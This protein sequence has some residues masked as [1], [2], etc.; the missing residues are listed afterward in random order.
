MRNESFIDLN[1]IRENARTIKR[2]LPKGVKLCAV[3]KS[4]AY[5]H[6]AAEVAAALYNVADCFA[7]ALTEEGVQLRQSGIDKDVLV[8]IP[9]L[10]SDIERAV[11]YNLTLT[12]DNRQVIRNIDEE[13]LKR[14]VKTKIHLKY[15]TGMNRFGVDTPEELERLCKYA[16][17]KNN[18]IIDGMFSHYACPE[19]D[20]LRKKARDKFLLAINVVKR[21]NK[22][23]TCHISAS[24]GF[25][26]GDYFDM[27]RVGILLYGYKPFACDCIKVKRAMKVFA[28]IMK[29]RRLS[30][31]DRAL[32][33]GKLSL[34]RRDL[35]LVRMGYADGPYRCEVKGQFN[36]RCMEIT[37][38]DGKYRG[39]RAC[40]MED[41]A[42]V[43]KRYGTIPYE[44]LIK[45]SAHTDKKYKR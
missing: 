39:R 43:A 1:A 42:A 37:A 44:I 36:N 11:A 45:Y 28:P 5:G 9:P 24:G 19:N 17:G 15:N 16:Q 38:L 13:S 12:A 4:D 34:I 41:A 2:I 35:S 33:G 14:G 8:M 18:V 40:V 21:Y 26:K 29:V 20:R 22:N 6:G 3:V 30:S 27:V 25:L 32:Y 10:P 23:V 31:F 7:V